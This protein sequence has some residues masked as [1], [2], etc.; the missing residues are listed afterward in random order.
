MDQ[1]HSFADDRLVV[2][3]IHC[4]AATENR[5]HVPSRVLLDEPYPENLAVLPSC[6]AC[7]TRFSLDEEYVAC[8]VE[9]ARTGSV[10]AVKRPKIRRIL[11]DSPALA[12]RLMQE[13]TV[14][15]S[16]EITFQPEHERVKKVAIKLARGHAAYELNEQKLD[17]PTHILFVPIHTLSRDALQH[18]ENPPPPVAWLEVGTRAMQRM[19]VNTP[20]NVVRA[21]SWAE[22]QESQYRYF[23]IAQGSVLVRFVI[24]EYLACEVMWGED[25]F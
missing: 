15:R 13:R 2:G 3:C 10:D 4:S 18:F 22:V 11:P 6:E 1:L 16:G 5:D 17:H 25:Q 9:C 24:G 8:L 19:V 7:N 21:T 23:A 14:A 20:S 12:A